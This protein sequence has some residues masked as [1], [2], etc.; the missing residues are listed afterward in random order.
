VNSRFPSVR[1]DSP[2]YRNLEGPVWVLLVVVIIL[3]PVALVVKMLKAKRDGLI[4]TK[5]VTSLC[6]QSI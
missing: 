5:E 2:E 1:C 4:A 6:K 3:I